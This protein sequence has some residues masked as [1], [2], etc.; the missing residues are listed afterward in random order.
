MKVP[1]GGKSGLLARDLQLL[2]S[3]VL[4]LNTHQVQW[5]EPNT[6]TGSIGERLKQLCDQ[7]QAGKS[8]SLYYYEKELCPILVMR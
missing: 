1:P 4:A 7:Y 3:L 6:G 8:E 2:S 5:V